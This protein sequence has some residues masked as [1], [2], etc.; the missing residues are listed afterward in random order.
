MLFTFPIFLSQ[1]VVLAV[2]VDDVIC[3]F[4]ITFTAWRFFWFVFSCIQT[5]Y[6]KIR[7][8]K[9]SVIGHFS[10]SV[11]IMES[12]HTPTRTF[13][14]AWKFCFSTSLSAVWFWELRW[15]ERALDGKMISAVNFDRSSIRRSTIFYALDPDAWA[16]KICIQI[17]K[18]EMANPYSRHL[19]ILRILDSLFNTAISEYSLSCAGFVLFDLLES[20]MLCGFSSTIIV[21]GCWILAWDCSSAFVGSSNFAFIEFDFANLIAVVKNPVIFAFGRKVLSFNS[22]MILSNSLER[23]FL[24]VYSID[25]WRVSVLAGLTI[26]PNIIF[27]LSKQNNFDIN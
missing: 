14:A 1:S 26:H 11:S 22:L 16:K 25:L 3:N 21:G 2:P 8:R 23:I 18:R 20:T 13:S 4:V 24:W 6:R 7:T 12:F 19:L 15:D 17:I 27:P 5:E 9:N 10:R